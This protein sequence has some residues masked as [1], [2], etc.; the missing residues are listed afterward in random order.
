MSSK[1]VTTKQC[2]HCGLTKDLTDFYKNS[3]SPDGHRS[4]C[5]ACHNRNRGT[6]GTIGTT[7]KGVTN[8]NESSPENGITEDEKERFG[9]PGTKL[10]V[11]YKNMYDMYE[12]VDLCPSC[13]RYNVLFKR[14]LAAQ[15][16]EIPFGI[17]NDCL[18]Q[19]D[20]GFVNFYTDGKMVYAIRSVEIAHSFTP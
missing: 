1:V 2:N 8:S 18:L 10:T 11:R 5:K 6:S 3:A 7:S 15:G 9:M 16:I 13:S 14:I 17:C 20:N 19:Y 12:K 4:V